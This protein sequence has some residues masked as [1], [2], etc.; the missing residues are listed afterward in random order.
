MI[1]L[2]VTD[3]RKDID[4]VFSAYKGEKSELI[5]HLRMHHKQRIV[6]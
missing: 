5:T 6:S 3:F 1:K 2:V 4:E